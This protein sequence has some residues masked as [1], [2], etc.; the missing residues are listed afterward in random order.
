MNLDLIQ[1][2]LQAYGIREIAGQADNAEIMQMA[3]D[4]GFTDYVHDEIA[5]CSLF[6]NWVCWKGNYQRSKSLAARSWLN[7]GTLVAQ[8]ELG[9][10]AVFWRQDPNSDFGHVAFPISRRNGLIY[11]LGGN[12]SN[13]VLIEGQDPT[14]LLGYRRLIPLAA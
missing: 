12:Q 13:A 4:C 3:R 2:A 1:I 11:T 7:M 5:W 10:I 14:K 8:P 6:L 9:D